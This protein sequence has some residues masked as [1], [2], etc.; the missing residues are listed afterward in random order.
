[1]LTLLIVLLI[2][3]LLAGAV[4]AYPYNRDWGYGP[5]G[6]LVFVVLVYVILRYFL[7]A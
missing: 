1:M 3:F 2:L 4:P 5:I 6:V 7:G